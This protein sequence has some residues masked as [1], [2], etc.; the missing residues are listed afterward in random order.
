MYLYVLMWLRGVGKLKM[1][2][3]KKNYN[4]KDL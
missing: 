3:K 2:A 1:I 4:Q